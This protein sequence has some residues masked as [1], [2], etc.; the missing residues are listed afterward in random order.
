MYYVTSSVVGF[1]DTSNLGRIFVDTGD[2]KLTCKFEIS[3]C[4]DFFK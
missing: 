4:E 3:L 2:T 1:D